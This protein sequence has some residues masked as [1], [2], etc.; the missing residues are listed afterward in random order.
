[1]SNF[2]PGLK[3]LE[4]WI[5]LTRSRSRALP[6]IIVTHY[7]AYLT[8]TQRAVAYRVIQKPVGDPRGQVRDVF[9]DNVKNVILAAIESMPLGPRRRREWGSRERRKV[10]VRVRA[11]GGHASRQ[12]RKSRWSVRTEIRVPGPAHPA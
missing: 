10:G 2:G 1:P 4:N 7:A 12:P 9:V 8:A 3:F 6:L 5:A 11:G